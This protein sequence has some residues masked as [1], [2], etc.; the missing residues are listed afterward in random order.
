MRKIITSTALI[1]FSLYFVY[2]FSTETENINF[3]YVGAKSGL[4]M[5]EKP[6]VKGKTITLI[7]EGEELVLI[8]EKSEKINIAGKKGKWSKIKWKDKTGWVFGGFLQTQEQ[9]RSPGM[10][11][12]VLGKRLSFQ[13][14]EDE[15]AD[16]MEIAI[17]SETTFEGS[18]LL[19]GSGEAKFDG[20]YKT[21]EGDDYDSIILILNG[22]LKGFVVAE[23]E[24]RFTRK[25]TNV[26]FLVRKKEEKLFGTL[27]IPSCEGFSEREMSAK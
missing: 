4:M 12:S 27:Q 9:Y 25:I 22:D 24:E 1:F 14:K 5:R 16:E 2:A 20:T 11:Y 18:C 15:L 21:E 3:R 7:P 6:D 10:I 19:H 23:K 13:L 17:S 8:E 26:K